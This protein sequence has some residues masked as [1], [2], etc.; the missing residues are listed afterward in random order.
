[1]KSKKTTIK[2]TAILYTIVCIFRMIEIQVTRPT[3]GKKVR[4]QLLKGVTHMSI[5]VRDVS[6]HG[7]LRSKT[8]VSKITMT[9]CVVLGVSA[10]EQKYHH[11][12]RQDRIKRRRLKFVSYYVSN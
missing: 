9:I 5:I 1:M 10:Y 7:L 8:H 3:H 12:T 6:E 11:K 2:T 4:F